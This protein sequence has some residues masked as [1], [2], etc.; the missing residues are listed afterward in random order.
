MQIP[1]ACFQ[2]WSLLSGIKAD[3][4]IVILGDMLELGEK[5][6]EEHIKL[7]KCASIP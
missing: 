5:S 1:Q 3:Q 4:K 7:I 2:L 6:E